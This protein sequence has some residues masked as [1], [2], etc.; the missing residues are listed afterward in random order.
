MKI[1]YK[2]FL[3]QSQNEETFSHKSNETNT[4][5]NIKKIS[6]SGNKSENSKSQ[7]MDPKEKFLKALKKINP[8]NSKMITLERY[9][10]L[11]FNDFY[12]NKEDFY[13]IKV[14][15]EI[16]CNESTHVVAAFKD[17]LINEDTSEF[18]QKFYT[19][20]ESK[21]ALPKIFEYYDCCSVIFPNYVVLPELKYIYKNIQRKQRVIDNQQ[22]LEDKQELIKNGIIKIKDDD[23][24]VFNTV[25][26]DSILDQ[27]NTSGIKR[28][29]GIKNRNESN[30]ESKNISIENIIKKIST[31][32]NFFQEIKNKKPKTNINLIAINSNKGR[33]YNRNT[34]SGYINNISN[35]KKNMNNIGINSIS[36]ISKNTKVSSTTI[37]IEPKNQNNVFYNSINNNLI[38]QYNNLGSKKHYLINN[39][40]TNNNKN[41]ITKTLE[42]EYKNKSNNQLNTITTSTSH[43]KKLKNL[44]NILP[45]TKKIHNKNKFNKILSSVNHIKTLSSSSS[46][47][48]Q[49]LITFHHTKNILSTS[50]LQSI[51]QKNIF[52][53]QVQSKENL[54]RNLNFREYIPFT[55]RESNNFNFENVDIL[56][57]K[58]K[59]L[60]KKISS[61]I[62]NKK[63]KSYNNINKQKEL[64]TINNEFNSLKQINHKKRKFN[65]KENFLIPLNSK[66]IPKKKRDQLS[67]SPYLF[68]KRKFSK[69]YSNFHSDGS[70]IGNNYDK[71]K[72]KN[73]KNSAFPKKEKN[74]KGLQIK[75]FKELIHNCHNYNSRNSKD[76]ISERI[77]LRGN[78]VSKTNFSN[79]TFMEIFATTH[80]KK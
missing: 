22:D 37:E 26:L 19:R 67:K 64:Q 41:T 35:S 6:S 58:L 43:K 5:K 40:L 50:K 53:V 10:F 24:P 78:S 12:S 39:L 29:F 56:N 7:V 55:S 79:K 76:F 9:V 60:N 17:Y 48:E 59:R 31:A 2:K 66:L 72:L 20:K 42:E 69:I 54:I 21:E 52:D 62:P 73:I 14:I 44:N 49:R 4:S 28:F 80:R 61:L 3:S 13:N 38:K 57:P 75:G 36:S 8:R 33:N 77:L 15:N 68:P 1:H 65:F 51:N 11:K 30:F 18:L 46:S 23:N 16:I 63:N 32:E 74:L 45:I 34:D 70:L 71:K 47:P 25:E 27:T